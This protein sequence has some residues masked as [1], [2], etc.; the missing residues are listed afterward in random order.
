MSYVDAFLPLLPSYLSHGTS[1]STPLE[2]R[3]VTF[4]T[5]TKYIASVFVAS[6]STSI[7]YIGVPI[8][9]VSATPPDLTVS[10]E[11]VSA[12]RVPSAT[13]FAQ[14]LFTPTSG[15]NWINCSTS[16]TEGNTYALVIRDQSI[17]GGG[18]TSCDATHDV[19]MGWQYAPTA[20]STQG[21][22][23]P[24]SV[25][26]D[27]ATVSFG[28][29]I[30]VISPK[31]I[32][33]SIGMGF[34]PI[35][36]ATVGWATTFNS[37]STPAQR[38]NVFSVP[39]MCKCGGAY[40]NLAAVNTSTLVTIKLIDGTTNTTLRTKS[41][42]ANTNFTGNN[43]KLLVEWDSVELVPNR[44]YRIIIN[45]TT[46]N[47]VYER[48]LIFS[49]IDDIR[50]S[51]PGVIMSKTDG[52]GTT[53]TDSSTELMIICPIITSIYSNNIRGIV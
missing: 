12:G 20:L 36:G 19:T 9:G 41:F 52:N 35:I 22:L 39:F 51:T 42:N 40:V 38:G 48:T 27:G 10:L 7:D 31:Y 23:S 8:A 43:G 25:Y 18:G 3:K 53:W 2:L 13:A 46:G 28:D 26:Y 5:T 37:G 14:T 24:M 11:S 44:N 33:G 29:D 1:P 6:K 15:Y 47:G 50:L 49:N 4:A 30:A 32:D 45:P 34:L 17:L 21:F 16:I